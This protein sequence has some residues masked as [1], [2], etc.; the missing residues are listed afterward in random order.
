MEHDAAVAT[1]D[2]FNKKAE[3]GAGFMRA[4]EGQAKQTREATEAAVAYTTE[5][6]A[7]TAANDALWQSVD[8]TAAAHTEAGAAAEAAGVQTVA[9][10]QGMAQ[11]VEITSDGV[12]GWLELMRATNAANSLLGQNSLFTS[13]ATLENQARLGT[14]FSPI[15]G[16]AGGV[17]NFGGGLAKVHGGEVLANLPPGT[18]VFPKGG[19]LGRPASPTSLTSSTP[20]R[21]WRSG[22]R[23]SS[24]GPF[25]PGRS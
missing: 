11:Q 4:V 18:S 12:R 6:D 3:A 9:A 25:D 2:A 10:Y 1:A 19:G 14:A 15:P 21:T 17:Q 20:S 22:S 8:Q 24:C 5:Q 16:F 13:G 23:N 7:L